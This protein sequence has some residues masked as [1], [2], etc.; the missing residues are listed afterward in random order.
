MINYTAQNTYSFPSAGFALESYVRANH[1]PELEKFSNVLA[2]PRSLARPMPNWR[3]PKVQLADT[4]QVTIARY[5]VGNKVRARLRGFG[6][7]RNPAYAVS[8]RFTD[9]T[10]RPVPAAEAS[11]WLRACLPIDAT[12]SLHELLDESAPTFCWLI[13]SHFCPLESPASLFERREQVA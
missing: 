5:R 10:G 9:T 8:A 1:L 11:A 3:P 2:H 6:E 12:Y 4:L 7:T 13:D